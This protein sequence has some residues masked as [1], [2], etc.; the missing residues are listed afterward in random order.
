MKKIILLLWLTITGLQLHAQIV[1]DSLISTQ[2]LN[3]AVPGI[4]AFQALGIEPGN[5]LRPSDIKSVALMVSEFQS[6]GSFFLPSAFAAEIAPVMLASPSVS[7]NEYRENK[8]FRFLYKTRLSMATSTQDEI[9]RNMTGGI[10]FA[11]IDK[12]DFK[13]DT[14]FLKENIFNALDDSMKLLSTAQKI[15][16]KQTNTS[17]ADF[18]DSVATSAYY[19]FILDSLYKKEKIK[20]VAAIDNAIKDY[21]KLNWNAQRLEVAYAINGASPDSSF[22]DISVVR[23]NLWVT[24]AQPLGCNKPWGQLLIGANL[25][26]EKIN[27]KFYNTYDIPIRLYAGSNRIKAFAELGL[28]FSNIDEAEK[29]ALINFGGEWNIIDGIWLNFSGGVENAFFS[30]AKSQ[31]VSNLKFNFTLPEKFKLN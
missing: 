21:K 24:Y 9:V 14:V 12:G 23:H 5:V 16:I 22:G 29:S 15:F 7:L 26:S 25:T 13:M 20:S 11:I 31:F 27:N 1:A 6:N 17:P 30:D 18:R 10:R 3:I 8:F 4:P 2:R 19:Q 28:I